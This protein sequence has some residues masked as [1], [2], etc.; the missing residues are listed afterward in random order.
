MAVV[1]KHIRKDTNETFYIGIGSLKRAH[2]SKG[3]NTHWTNVVNKAGYEVEIILEGLEWEQ[4]CIEEVRLIKQYGRKDLNEGPLTN[5][6]DGGEGSPNA[7]Q[8]EEKK[9]KCREAAL[10]QSNRG[11]QKFTEEYKQ[12]LSERASDWHKKNKYTDEQRKK[13]SDAA[14]KQHQRYKDEGRKY[15]SPNHG[16]TH[17]DEAKKKMSDA[18]RAF[19][20]AK[21]Q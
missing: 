4:A 17:S 20:K 18:R 9:A 8:S 2:Q 3:R 15:T 11:E 7:F 12:H 10:K 5:M 16:N 6:T 1:Y 19:W 14:K 21:K 13:M